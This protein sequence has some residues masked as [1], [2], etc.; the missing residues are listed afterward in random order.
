M[1]VP[2]VEAWYHLPYIGI[3]TESLTLLNDSSVLPTETHSEGIQL[4][5]PLGL[6]HAHTRYNRP[7]LQ[8]DV[9]DG[10]HVQDVEIHERKE[11]S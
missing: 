3:F 1:Q 10:R 5:A 11:F 8:D 6:A 7:A 9:T 4:H 2:R